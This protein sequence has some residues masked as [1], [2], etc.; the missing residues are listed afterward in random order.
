[1][2]NGDLLTFLLTFDR[3]RTQLAVESSDRVYL[4]REDEVIAQE[5]K[6]QTMTS[7]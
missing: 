3:T 7:W 6:A 1:M 4:N 2:L 5:G